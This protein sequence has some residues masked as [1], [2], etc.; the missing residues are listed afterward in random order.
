M[1][2]ASHFLSGLFKIVR[3]FLSMQAA[4]QCE[5]HFFVVSFT[6]IFREVLSSDEI[7]RVNFGA[8]GDNYCQM[9]PQ[10]CHIDNNEGNTGDLMGDF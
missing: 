10:K 4:C 3:L 6:S 9:G 8:M 7:R 2:F 1:R 5:W